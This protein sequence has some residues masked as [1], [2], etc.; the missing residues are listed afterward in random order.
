MRRCWLIAVDLSARIPTG[1]RREISPIDRSVRF[2]KSRRFRFPLLPKLIIIRFEF[3]TRLS[4]VW[5]SSDGFA[6]LFSRPFIEF[7]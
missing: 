1:N 6:P 5:N 2:E 4:R 7:R 3:V